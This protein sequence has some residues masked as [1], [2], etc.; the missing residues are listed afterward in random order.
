[1]LALAPEN[2]VV[3]GKKREITQTE[4]SLLSIRAYVL[5]NVYYIKI[6]A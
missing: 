4:L 5:F 2:T 6:F 3:S 1:M